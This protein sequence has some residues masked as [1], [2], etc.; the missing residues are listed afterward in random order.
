MEGQAFLRSY[1]SAPYPLSPCPICKLDRR[2]TGRPRIRD[3]LMTGK[4][5]GDGL[6]AESYDRKKDWPSINQSILPGGDRSVCSTTA[7]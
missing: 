3:N 7:D 6:G 4:D 1:D 2:H 5:G